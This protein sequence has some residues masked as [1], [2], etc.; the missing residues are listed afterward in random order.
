MTQWRVVLGSR[1]PRRR[2]L[3]SPVIDVQSIGAKL[4]GSTWW[5]RRS[6]STWADHRRRISAQAL[7]DFGGRRIGGPNW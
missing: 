5:A 1:G 2:T 3:S 4:T 6:R 7:L